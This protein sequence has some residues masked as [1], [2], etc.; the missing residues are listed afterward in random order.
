MWDVDFGLDLLVGRAHLVEAWSVLN[1]WA[2]RHLFVF[3]QFEG[4]TVVL[5]LFAVLFVND[6]IVDVLVFLPA[7]VFSTEVA[8]LRHV[9]QVGFLSLLEVAQDLRAGGLL[10]CVEQVGILQ[11][12][13]IRN[14]G[15][16]PP[17]LEESLFDSSEHI[18]VDSV[19]IVHDI[20]EV[21][22][23]SWHASLLKVQAVLLQGSNL[24]EKELFIALELILEYDIEFLLD[25]SIVLYLLVHL[26]LILESLIVEQGF[27]SFVDWQVLL[28]LE[29]VLASLCAD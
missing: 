29:L 17:V 22:G 4:E 20:L 23:M 6:D 8:V 15:I 24:L 2:W 26:L 21:L 1:S 28:L 11:S 3:L 12:H 5:Y 19:R 10:P 27:F 9:Q 13:Q 25:D 7:I 16:R 18:E 14:R